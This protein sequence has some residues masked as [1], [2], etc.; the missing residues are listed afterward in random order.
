MYREEKAI[1]QYLVRQVKAAGGLCLKITSP[2]M[3]GI[4]DRLVLLPGNFPAFIELKAPGQKPRPLQ[5]AA[6]AMLRRTG[7]AIVVGVIDTKER[8]DSFMQVMA[9]RRG[10]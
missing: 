2:S 10:R 4:P 6:M 9:W 5:K 8:V 7:S 3:D 1:E